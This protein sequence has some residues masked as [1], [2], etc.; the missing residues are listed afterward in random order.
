[1]LPRRR[2]RQFILAQ[3]S[4]LVKFVYI[5]QAFVKCHKFI[6]EKVNHGAR[7]IYD[8]I[9]QFVSHNGIAGKTNSQTESH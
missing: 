9:K 6:I 3:I 2:Y 4:K 8:I 1:M 7:T 5:N